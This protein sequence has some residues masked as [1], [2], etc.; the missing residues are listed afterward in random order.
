MSSPVVLCVDPDPSDREATVEG[1]SS[2]ADR[3]DLSIQ[4]VDTVEAAQRVL[5]ESAVDCLITE[6]DLEDGSGIDLIRTVR[7]R[8]PDTG[9]ILYTDRIPAEIDTAGA[10]LTITEFLQKDTPRALDRLAELVETIISENTQTSYPVPQDEQRRRS[11]LRSY[12]LESERLEAALKR[13]T[14]VAAAGI[15]TPLASVNIIEEHSQE[16]L[17][18]HGVDDHWESID[19]EHAVCTFTIMEDSGVMAVEDLAADPRF[20]NDT[21]LQGFQFR[22]YLGATLRTPAGL[23]IGSL[24]VYDEEPRRFSD[25]EQAFL[26]SLAD[27]TM[28]LIEAFNRATVSEENDE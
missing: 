20:A 16:F 2:T 23:A 28:D 1:L 14:D 7:N 19:R 11:A 8:R 13:I 21:E 24:C 15:D 10:E 9:C 4:A 26:R 12:D 27:V 17:V 3:F 22:S 6:Y 25:D 5:D 18:C